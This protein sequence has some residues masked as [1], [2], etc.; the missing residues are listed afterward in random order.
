MS[1]AVSEE[2]AEISYDTIIVCKRQF[3]TKL[4]YYLKYKVYNGDVISMRE[5]AIKRGSWVAVMIVGET[6]R[7]FFLWLEPSE[8]KEP[9]T[10]LK[11]TTMRLQVHSLARS[12]IWLVLSFWSIICF[13]HTFAWFFTHLVVYLCSG[14]VF[15]S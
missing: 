5:E 15:W 10:S 7:L 2:L 3:V 9:Q 1:Y 4:G 14:N 8:R 12:F 11:Q 6:K 13:G